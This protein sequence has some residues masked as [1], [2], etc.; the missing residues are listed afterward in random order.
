MKDLSHSI[1][2]VP[3]FYPDN[4]RHTL[5]DIKN[6]DVGLALRRDLFFLRIAV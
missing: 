3:L 2:A 6:I 5:L 1:A 4:D